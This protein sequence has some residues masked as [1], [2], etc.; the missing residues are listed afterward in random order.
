[1]TSY[2]VCFMN[3]IGCNERLFRCWQRSFLIRS[4]RSPERAIEAAKK[5]FTRWSASA[6]GS[7]TLL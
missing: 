3:E 5:R 2:R 7:F 6:N 1:M 4:A